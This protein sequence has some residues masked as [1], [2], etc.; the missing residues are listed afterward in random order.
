MSQFATIAVQVKGCAALLE[1]VSSLVGFGDEYKKIRRKNGRE[2]KELEAS[3][4]RIASDY[5]GVPAVL[6][7][8]TRHPGSIEIHSDGCNFLAYVA[9]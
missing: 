8:I 9:R 4:A 3:Y 7:A 5:G 6:N 2:N 1:L